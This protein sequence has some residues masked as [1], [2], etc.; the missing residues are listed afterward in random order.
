MIKKNISKKRTSAAGQLIKNQDDPE[1][2]DEAEFITP[3]AIVGIEDV[4]TV[5]IEDVHTTTADSS[6]YQALSSDALNPDSD[7]EIEHDY[8]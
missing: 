7:Y 3:Y 4:H 6:E 5:G 2:L 1:A 8:Y